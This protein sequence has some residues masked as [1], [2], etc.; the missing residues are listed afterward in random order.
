MV[1]V[2]IGLLFLEVIVKVIVEVVKAR[3][4][5]GQWV[6]AGQV[7]VITHVQIV[8]AVISRADDSGSLSRPEFGSRT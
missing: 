2:G 6:I 3:L 5:I 7:V 8:L 1:P 4:F